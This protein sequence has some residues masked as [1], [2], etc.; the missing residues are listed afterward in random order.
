[1]VGI[2]I[3][4]HSLLSEALIE[5]SRMIMGEQIEKCETMALTLGE[6]LED[7]EEKFCRRLDALDEGDGVLVMV[8]LFAGTPANTAMRSMRE[9]NFECISGV[10]LAMVLEALASR[11]YQS[12]KEVK[13][14]ALE[15]ARQSIVDVGKIVKGETK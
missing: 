6:D 3:A 7:F 9:R 11:N 10:N 13:E 5:S 4:T 12:L 15:A 2:L 1:M 8:D 14:A